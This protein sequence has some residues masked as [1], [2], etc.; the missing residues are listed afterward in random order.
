MAALLRWLLCFFGLHSYLQW[1]EPKHQ[2]QM[3]KC[4]HCKKV[5]F[6]YEEKY[7]QRIDGSEPIREW[8]DWDSKEILK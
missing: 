1:Y 4:I 5:Q 6:L 7:F 8:I 2:V 3:R